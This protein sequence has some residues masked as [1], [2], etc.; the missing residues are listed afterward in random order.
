MV[1]S[2]LTLTGML[3]DPLIQLVNRSDNVSEEDFSE[4]MLRVQDVLVT[5][6]QAAQATGHLAEA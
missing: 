6:D 4:L 3:Q 1:I 2:T 5:R